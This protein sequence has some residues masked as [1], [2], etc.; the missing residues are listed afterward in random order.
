MTEARVKTVG[1]RDV[2]ELYQPQLSFKMDFFGGNSV[3]T[4]II[5][6]QD[7]KPL[8]P[9]DSYEQVL[10]YVVVTMKVKQRCLTTR[11]THKTKNFG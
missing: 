5:Q 1:N 9:C 10:A 2:A 6:I 3:E 8:V 4:E 7:Q 11:L